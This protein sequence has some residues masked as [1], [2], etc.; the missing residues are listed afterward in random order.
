[1][2]AQ[3]VWCS[4]LERHTARLKELQD[5]GL[6]DEHPLIVAARRRIRGAQA[7][8]DREHGRTGTTP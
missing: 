6:I 2:T 8:D 1:V 5:A 3:C 7:F 4:D